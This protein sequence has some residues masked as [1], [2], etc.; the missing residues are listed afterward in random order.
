[1]KNN[2]QKMRKELGLTQSQLAEMVG[3]SARTI[4]N[5]EKGRTDIRKIDIITA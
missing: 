4:Q 3:I 1:M 5:Y 2:L